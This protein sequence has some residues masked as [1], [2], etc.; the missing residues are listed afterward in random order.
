MEDTKQF[1]PVLPFNDSFKDAF[2]IYDNVTYR[3]DLAL[4]E[5]GT[6]L[7][8]KNMIKYYTA[9]NA[10]PVKIGGD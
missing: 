10:E 4:T 9:A 6:M 7:H 2:L 1:T 3:R 8:N 5:C